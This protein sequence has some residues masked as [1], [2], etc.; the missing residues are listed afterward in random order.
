MA[1]GQVDTAISGKRMIALGQRVDAVERH[2]RGPAPD[3]DIAA[4]EH[5][6]AR[7]LAALQPAEQELG[8]Q[9]ERDGD[10]RLGE[11]ALIAV[12]VQGQTRSRR[13]TVNEA[14]VAREAGKARCRRGARGELSKEPRHRRPGLVRH[15]IRRGIA[16]A[17]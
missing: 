10:D 13:I 17:A 15:W 4:L 16:I 1:E 2:A 14:G 11:I 9:P 7:A 12:L 5:Y 8:P 6:P 3:D